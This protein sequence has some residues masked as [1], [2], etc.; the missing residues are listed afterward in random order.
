MARFREGYVASRTG[1]KLYWRID[2]RRGTPLVCCNGA[3]VG[4]FFWEP[5][6]RQL[7]ED[8]QVVRFDWRGHGR[9]DSPRDPRDISVGRCAEDLIDLMNGLGLDRA[10]VLGHSVGAQVAFEL[11]HRDP[12]RVAALI[13]TL[14]TYRRA[15][16][17]FYDTRLFLVAFALIRRVVDAAPELVTLATRPLLIS[18]VAE[19]CARLVGLIDP[20]LAPHEF[21]VPLM[22]HLI[23]IDPRTLVALAQDA[24]RH[25]ASKVLPTIDVPVLVVAAER[26]VFTPPRLAREMVALIPG[27]EL[28]LIPNATHAALVEQPDLLC[29]RVAKFLEERVQVPGRP[30]T[31]R[32]KRAR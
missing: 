22:E 8:H 7:S 23:R 11:F 19:K 28:L 10:V 15:L 32:K 21:M 13:P 29:L 24:Q 30:R 5:F 3:G 2:G 9:S 27:A 17:T 16:E 14:A 1:L 25:D 26:D 6:A 18:G 20:A 4:I 31:K 12:S